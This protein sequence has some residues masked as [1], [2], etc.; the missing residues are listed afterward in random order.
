M[1][2]GKDERNETSEEQS[3]REEETFHEEWKPGWAGISE[4]TTFGAHSHYF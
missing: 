3:E 4:A 1:F 2:E